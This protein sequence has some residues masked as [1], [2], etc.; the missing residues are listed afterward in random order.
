MPRESVLT[1]SFVVFLAFLSSHTPKQVGGVFFVGGILNITGGNFSG[2]EASDNGGILRADE[3]STVNLFD[4]IFEGNEANDGGVVSVNEGGNVFVHGG[5]YSDNIADS[6]GVVQID[7]YVTLF[8]GQF[9]GNGAY[10]GGVVFVSYGGK[11]IV[12]GGIYSKNNAD[13][14][15]GVFWRDDGGDLEVMF[16]GALILSFKKGFV[17]FRLIYV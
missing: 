4:G 16:W 11:L 14:G 1:K 15:G 10:N 5:I 13:N 7:G 17:V 2:N 8:D 9:E 12:Q 6:G 3:E